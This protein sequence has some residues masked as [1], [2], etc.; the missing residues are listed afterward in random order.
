MSEENRIKKA[1]LIVDDDELFL[2]MVATGLQMQL[3]GVQV[4]FAQTGSSA[5]SF[6][7]THPVDLV[8]TDLYMPDVDGFEILFRVRE[9]CPEVPVIIVT[10]FRF[11]DVNVFVKN[12]G[13][14]LFLEKPFDVEMLARSVQQILSQEIQD[15]VSGFT[16]TSFLQLMELDKKTSTLRVFS[17]GREG[18][19]GFRDGRLVFAAAGSLAGEDAAFEIL[20]W[21]EPEIRIINYCKET[22]ANIDLSLTALLME[23]CREID[24]SRAA[25]FVHHSQN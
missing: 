18:L 12:L 4:F 9:H 15:R 2:E 22:Q 1:V 14:A 24:E 19:L 20:R 25:P 11:A 10:G 13:C 17:A 3:P 23:S 8:I 5:V 7:Q 21:S 16:L 6:V